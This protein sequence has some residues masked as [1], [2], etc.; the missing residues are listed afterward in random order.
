MDNVPIFPRVDDLDQVFQYV[1]PTKSTKKPVKKQA[2]KRLNYDGMSFNQAFASALQAG[3]SVFDWRG[4]KYT[5]QLAP[6]NI[7]VPMP[8]ID[9]EPMDRVYNPTDVSLHQYTPAAAMASYQADAGLRRAAM[10]PVTGP[11][12]GV[13]VPQSFYPFSPKH[14]DN[15]LFSLPL[16]IQ[17]ITSAFHQSIVNY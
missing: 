12:S 8:S 15:Q 17:S 7:E 5:T 14:D 4:K 13:Q 6:E 3:K 16:Y 9:G 2:Q 1:R 10:Q 11:L